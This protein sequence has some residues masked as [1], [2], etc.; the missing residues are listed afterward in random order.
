MTVCNIRRPANPVTGLTRRR[1]FSVRA[2]ACL[3][4]STYSF[5]SSPA[6]PRTSG[7]CH[8]YARARDDLVHGEEHLSCATESVDTYLAITLQRIQSLSNRHSLQS[9]SLRQCLFAPRT[10]VPMTHILLLLLGMKTNRRCCIVAFYS[11][12]V[13]IDSYCHSNAQVHNIY[14]IIYFSMS[15]PIC[16]AIYYDIQVSDNIRCLSTLI[17]FSTFPT[18]I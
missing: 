14:I 8:R 1:R 4:R 13:Y 2:V 12:R 7:L 9:L 6:F 5:T 16:R 3:P 10:V 17:Q 11:G 15:T 18:Q